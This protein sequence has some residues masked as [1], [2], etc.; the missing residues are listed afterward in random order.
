MDAV[1]G[2]QLSST[3]CTQF[4]KLSDNILLC[5]TLTVNLES[6]TNLT[7][8]SLGNFTGEANLTATLLVQ[9][10]LCEVVITNSREAIVNN[11][12]QFVIMFQSKLL[13][14]FNGIQEIGNVVHTTDALSGAQ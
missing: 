9:I 5:D 7:F 14:E 10:I 13:R 3:K 1:S 11:F 6:I 12:I 2:A 4:H 8:Y